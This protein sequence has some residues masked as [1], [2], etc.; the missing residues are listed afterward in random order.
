[1]NEAVR[2][3]K[4]LVQRLGRPTVNR[5]VIALVKSGR[6]FP[7]VSGSVLVIET[8][9]RR[10]GKLRCTPMGF[11]KS[12]PGLVYVVAEHGI[13]SDW[14]RNALAAGSFR[15]W[16]DGGR[17]SGKAE[18]TPDKDPLEV[19][20]LIP[21]RMVAAAN[22]LLSYDAKVVEINLTEP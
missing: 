21:S 10:S 11:V 22:H 2:K 3:R 6:R 7:F 1:L 12:S 20:R 9:G 18:L 5:L 4:K 13:R 19:R 16:L 14:V 8:K 15:V 17:F